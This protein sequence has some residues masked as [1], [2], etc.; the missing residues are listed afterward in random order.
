MKKSAVSLLSVLLLAFAFFPP[1]IHAQGVSSG[2][3]TYVQVKDKEVT[4]GDIIKFTTAG[5]Q[6]TEVEYEPA[7]Y[8]VVVDKPSVSFENTNLQGAKAV[9]SGGKVYVRVNTSNGEIKKGT[10]I[11]SS[12]TPGIGMRA[13]QNGYVIGTAVEGFNSSDKKAIGK[14]LVILNISY[15]SSLSAKTNNLFKLFTVAADAPYLSPLNALRYVFA[16]ILIIVSFVIAVGFF[17]KVSNTGVEAIGRNPLA[18][19]MIMVS[20][21]MHLVLAAGIIGIGVLMA[22]LL[23]VL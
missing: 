17:G 6:K 23:L 3:A 12:N 1:L 9:V 10:L 11:T 22:Y 4:E 13:S 7:V 2:I 18:G 16:G 20:V 8:G 15:N 14:V 21:V 19:K 5:Y